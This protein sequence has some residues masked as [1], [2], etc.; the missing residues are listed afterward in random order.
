MISLYSVGMERTT[1]GECKKAKHS[2]ITIGKQQIASINKLAEYAQM[3][4]EILKR[5]KGL[6]CRTGLKGKGTGRK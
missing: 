1:L 6:I 3:L 2:A 5:F 4:K